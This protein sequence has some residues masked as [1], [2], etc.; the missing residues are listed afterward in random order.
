MCPSLVGAKKA[1]QGQ[2][3]HDQG[4]VST[5]DHCSHRFPTGNW[6]QIQAPMYMMFSVVHHWFHFLV[7]LLRIRLICVRGCGS[8]YCRVPRFFPAGY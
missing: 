3:E 8:S 5:S 2:L 4:Q 1:M 7:L 6:A